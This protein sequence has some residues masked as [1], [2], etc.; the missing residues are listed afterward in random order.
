MG[1]FEQAVAEYTKAIELDDRNEE[2]FEAR[3]CARMSYLEQ[4]KQ[5]LVDTVK[6]EIDEDVRM[7]V[8]LEA[9]NT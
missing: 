9:T 3:S 8:E 1:Q 5:E 7:L 2:Y 6:A 4:K